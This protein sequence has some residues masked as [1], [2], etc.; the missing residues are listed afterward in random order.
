VVHR[1][2]LNVTI[3]INSG[4]FTDVAAVCKMN[5]KNESTP[6]HSTAI[7]TVRTKI[8][9]KSEEKLRRPSDRTRH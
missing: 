2:L 4:I 6:A 1:F 9:W 7:Q 8:T 5:G 3:F